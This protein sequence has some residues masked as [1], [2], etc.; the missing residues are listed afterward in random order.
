MYHLMRL[1]QWMSNSSSSF[2]FLS[3]SPKK[4]DTKQWII[5]IWREG[6]REREAINFTTRF[7]DV[8]NP[9]KHLEKR[10]FPYPAPSHVALSPIG[11]SLSP[12]FYWPTYQC[13]SLHWAHLSLLFAIKS[14][15]TFTSHFGT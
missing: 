2:K 4:C 12:V 11:L 3:S 14:N 15:S 10:R 1:H 6:G 5:L 9:T 13:L 8:W 7:S